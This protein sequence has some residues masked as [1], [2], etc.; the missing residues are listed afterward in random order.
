MT[1]SIARYLKDFGEAQSALPPAVIESPV[2]DL[3]LDFPFE[4]E[5]EPVRVDLDAVRAAAFEEGHASALAEAEEKWKAEREKLVMSHTRELNSLRNIV[6][7]DIAGRLKSLME[8][9]VVAVA[10]AVSDEVASVLAPVLEEK[11]LENALDEM[12]D[13]LRQALFSGE[14]VVLTVHCSLPLFEKL[15]EKIGD[16]AGAIKHVEVEDID[17]SVDIDDAVLVSRL[18]A[19]SASL[20]KVL[21]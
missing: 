4:P 15:V 3:S 5:P 13:A 2:D 7:Y 11:I 18:S 8:R 16:G 20:K 19:W 1:S 21:G 6:E 10:Q 14:A 9:S 17:V 12:S